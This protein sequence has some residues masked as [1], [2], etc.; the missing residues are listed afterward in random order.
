MSARRSPTD[1]SHRKIKYYSLGSMPEKAAILV[2]N[3]LQGQ[4]YM[5]FDV[6]V[7]RMPG[8]PNFSVSL[9]TRYPAKAADVL[10]F[11]LWA[12]AIEAS[13]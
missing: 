10:T 9:G 12:I 13:S 2:Y 6:S 11:A 5:T 3:A 4:T 1:Y 7:G 8:D